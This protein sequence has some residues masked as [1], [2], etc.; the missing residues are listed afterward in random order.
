M[1]AGTRRPE[2]SLGQQATPFGRIEG[3]VVDPNHPAAGGSDGEIGRT[4]MKRLA[5][6][7]WHSEQDFSAPSEPAGDPHLKRCRWRPSAPAQTLPS[8]CLMT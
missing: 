3:A 2:S 1:F 8:S 5:P 4:F 7:Q 6:F